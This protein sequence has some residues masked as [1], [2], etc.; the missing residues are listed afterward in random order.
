LITAPVGQVFKGYLP[1]REV[2]VGQGLFQSCAILGGT[3]MPHT[4]YLGSGIVQARMRKFDQENGT[5]HET[6]A[7]DSER[8]TMLYR[9]TLSAI[10]SCMSFTVAE[11]CITLFIV[12][13]FVNSSI[14]IVAAS[15]LTESA[16]DIQGIYRLF[17][18][19]ISQASGTVFALALLFSGVTAGIVTTM[20]GQLVCEGAFNWRMNT[21]LRRFI[22]RLVAIIP[23]II[24][25]ASLGQEGL[26][27]A[28]IG[29]DVVRSVTLIVITLPLIWYTSCSKYMTVA[30]D[31]RRA[32]AVSDGCLIPC[33]PGS[34][35]YIEAEAA[36]HEADSRVCVSGNSLQGT[37]SMASS[38]PLRITGWII[39]LIIAGVNVAT[40]T[41]LGL[42]IDSD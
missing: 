21:F 13:I 10:K 3:I 20:A 2:F 39:W 8:S 31:D 17:V 16:D 23:A 28:L 1:S 24:V 41:F 29:T 38:W 36:N 34:P 18:D 27:A 33:S 26:A 9:P 32:V 37:V 4:L 15:A 5:Y 19:T 11:L 40:L 25:A 22:I 30:Q 14:L 6:K 12:S 7:W 42:G 35:G